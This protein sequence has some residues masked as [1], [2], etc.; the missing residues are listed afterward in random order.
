VRPVVSTVRAVGA[1]GIEEVGDLRAG[2]RV[3]EPPPKSR[4]N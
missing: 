4:S 1:A 3:A 2:S